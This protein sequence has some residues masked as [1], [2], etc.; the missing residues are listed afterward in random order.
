MSIWN[1]LR[2]S[3]RMLLREPG[4]A[5]V[6]ILTVALGVGANTAIFSIVNGVLLRPLPTPIRI[7]WWPSAK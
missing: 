1:D 4:F 5:T 6:A 7:A 2:Y 3:A